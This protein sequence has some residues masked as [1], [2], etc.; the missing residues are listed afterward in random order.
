MPYL[1]LA[2]IPR[3]AGIPFCGRNQRENK[4]KVLT[5]ASW[6]ART[7]LD[8]TKV[9]RPERRT[10]LV[11]RELDRYKVDIAALSETR[12]TH[13]GQLTETGGGYTFFGADA[14][15]ERAGGKSGIRHQNNTA[16]TTK[17]GIEPSENTE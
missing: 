15:V 1:T 17:P 13:K 3:L 11:A 6:N 8:N 16:L 14:S 2:I 10:A 4:S 7:L 9:D 5:L 12:F